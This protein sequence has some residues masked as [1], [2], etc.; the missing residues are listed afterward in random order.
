MLVSRCFVEGERFLGGQAGPHGQ[1]VTGPA[2]QI[3]LQLQASAANLR[4]DVGG[5]R[6]QFDPTVPLVGQGRRNRLGELENNRSAAFDKVVGGG[7][8]ENKRTHVPQFNFSPGAQAQ[9]LFHRGKTG[10]EDQPPAFANRQWLS[11]RG[12]DQ[13]DQVGSQIGRRTPAPIFPRH[14]FVG[15]WP[16]VRRAALAH[17][18]P[19]FD[20]R[21]QVGG[22][23]GR[24][25]NQR[26][27]LLRI[28]IR[29]MR[30]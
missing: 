13:Q 20:I 21:R 15:P 23:N 4:S 11:R 18:V 8:L 16:E 6:L 28:H 24:V 5:Q 30:P 19:E 22:A 3:P 14:V 17:G 26:D 7:F 25:E 29:L 10:P 1:P 2:V 12:Q 9:S 27:F